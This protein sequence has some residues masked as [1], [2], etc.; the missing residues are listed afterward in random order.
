MRRGYGRGAGRGFGRGRGFRNFAPAYV[1][2]VQPVYQ[3]YNNADEKQ[4]L[5]SDA[6]YLKS[7]L[8]AVNKRLQQL[9]SE[10]KSDS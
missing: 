1:P 8:D 6:E 9:E 2:A 3:P 5:K 7:Q 4:V 10:K